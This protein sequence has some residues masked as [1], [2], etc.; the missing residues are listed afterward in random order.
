[1]QRH[2][3]KLPLLA[4]GVAADEALLQLHIRHDRLQP[5]DIV[6]GGVVAAL[7]L[8]VQH[9]PQARNHGQVAAY[10]NAHSKQ[11]AAGSGQRTCSRQCAHLRHTSSGLLH[12]HTTQCTHGVSEGTKE[13]E[14]HLNQ[15][16]HCE[17]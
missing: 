2:G 17:R 15:V 9:A 1:M 16:C 8:H 14:G 10:A 6:H 13:Q 4:N 12:K 11:S 3:R 5:D 7:G